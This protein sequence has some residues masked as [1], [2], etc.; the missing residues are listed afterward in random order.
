MLRLVTWNILH[1][2]GR[3]RTPG[4]ALALLELRPDVVVLTEFRSSMGG[5]LAGVLSDHGLRHRLCTDPPP[6]RNGVLIASRRAIEP[7]KTIEKP[8]PALAHRWLAGR[9]PA[10]D[11]AIAGVHLPDDHASGKKAAAWRHTLAFARAHADA[12]CV[13]LGDFN[14]VRR[15]TRRPADRSEADAAA[16]AS[17]LG[18]LATLG[19][20]DAWTAANPGVFASERGVN[21]TSAPLTHTWTSRTGRGLRLDQAWISRSISGDLVAAEHGSPVVSACESRLSD[22]AWVRVDLSLGPVNPE[23]FGASAEAGQR[24]GSHPTL[25]F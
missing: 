13:I 11:L 18:M 1:G 21:A 17:R 14:T 16:S 6:G 19:Y 8:P 12:K 2:G 9:L 25:F 24:P 15:G 4:I 3:T 7:I 10:F 22:H 5:Q 20:T 23:A